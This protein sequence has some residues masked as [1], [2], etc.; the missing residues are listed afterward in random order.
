MWPIAQTR[1]STS[2]TS[3]SRRAP[4]K[5]EHRSYPQSS[6]SVAVTTNRRQSWTQMSTR[7]Q[8]LP[9]QRV[10]RL[11]AVQLSLRPLRC[12][13]PPSRPLSAQSRSQLVT[14]A[15]SDEE[16]SDSDVSS[17]GLDEYK[18]RAIPRKPQP[19]T[20]ARPHTA[21]NS[22][23]AVRRVTPSAPPSRPATAAASRQ[24]YE[25][26][27]LALRL[28][29]N[30]AIEA[31]KPLSGEEWRARLQQLK[32]RIVAEGYSRGER[33]DT[34]EEEKEQLELSTNTDTT[35]HSS[36]PSLDQASFA[37]AARLSQQ[38]GLSSTAR[39]TAST[40]PSPHTTLAL[41][42]NAYAKDQEGMEQELKTLKRDKRHLLALIDAHTQQLAAT[43]QRH[44]RLVAKLTAL[45]QQKGMLLVT[46]ADGRTK[47]EAAGEVGEAEAVRLNP[48]LTTQQIAASLQREVARL[49]VEKERKECEQD[50][51]EEQ[52][53]LEE[54]RAA[55]EDRRERRSSL[56]DDDYSDD[57]AQQRPRLTQRHRL[58]AQREKKAALLQ[59]VHD[60]QEQ[61]QR[62]SGET[63][64]RSKDQ[65]ASNALI[66]AI[67]TARTHADTYEGAAAAAA[68]TARKCQGTEHS[69][70][71]AAAH[72]YQQQHKSGQA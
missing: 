25:P 7:A 8:Y 15:I 27:S 28:E 65:A 10:E 9:P 57:D 45:A 48:L 69:T 12:R 51:I 52:Q 55:D 66:A 33:L 29:A 40:A 53:R 41:K 42:W 56:A 62:S 3:T 68:T 16:D 49:E 11:V 26:S 24:Q 4:T 61:L 70:V 31:I 43:Q 38:A 5:T 20:A 46:A 14:S 13:P 50:E 1:R 39:S 6:P 34:G 64:L 30:G 59:K 35:E 21:D 18:Q 47:A 60:L 2:S 58:R 17:D 36:L 71:A 23:S 22:A 67:A 37:R 44:T 63:A 54:E 19:T 72:R 32:A